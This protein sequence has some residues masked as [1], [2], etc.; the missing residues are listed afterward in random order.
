MIEIVSGVFKIWKKLNFNTFLLDFFLD[1][2]MISL[3]SALSGYIS[4]HFWLKTKIQDEFIKKTLQ[5]TN[6]NLFSYKVSINCY[7]SNK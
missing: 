3:K 1:V 5:L 7:Y 4:S 6:E 2:A